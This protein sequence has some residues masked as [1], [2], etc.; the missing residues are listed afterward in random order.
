MESLDSFP[1]DRIRDYGDVLR[2]F[3]RGRVQ[4]D[5]ELV[6]LPEE[7]NLLALRYWCFLYGVL[8]YE[9][10][11]SALELSRTGGQTRSIS[12]LNRCLYEYWI[13]LKYYIKRP[14]H[15]AEDIALAKGRFR[16]IAEA[17][18][19]EYAEVEFDEE[20]FEKA[21]EGI[22][23][24]VGQF[25][26]FIDM[27]DVAMQSD[28]EVVDVSYRYYYALQSIYVHGN[29]A[30][31][32]DLSHD[33]DLDLP[34]PGRDGL[35]WTSRRLSEADVISQTVSF[36]SYILHLIE[37]ITGRGAAFVVLGERYPRIVRAIFGR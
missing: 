27:L 23:K 28:K 19:P 20:A 22:E 31:F 24:K 32:I 26:R 34:V 29:E 6:G 25:R 18:P 15:A 10:S 16:S 21:F 11:G 30:A 7:P 2:D 1:I 33:S 5:Y 37:A 12:I 3:L 9:I 8:A 14:E 35:D 17:F 13:R 36:T 4:F